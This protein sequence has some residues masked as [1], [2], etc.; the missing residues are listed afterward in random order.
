MPLDHDQRNTLNVGGNVTLPWRSYGVANI[1]DGS[2][3]T[4]VFPGAPYPG[5]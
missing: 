3:F 1:Y 2:G 4:K 5:T